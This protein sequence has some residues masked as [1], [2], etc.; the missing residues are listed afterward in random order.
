METAVR[1][2]SSGSRELPKLSFPKWREIRQGFI[3][4]FIGFVFL[5]MVALPGLLLLGPSKWTVV[6]TFGIRVDAAMAIGEVLAIFGGGA[7]YLF[8]VLGQLR[9]LI[10]SPQRHAGKELLFSAFLCS[11]T[12]PFLFLGAHFLDGDKNYAFITD[13]IHNLAYVDLLHGGGLLQLCGLGLT[14]LNILLFSGF[15]RGT[16]C[17]F[18]DERRARALTCYFWFMAFLVGGTFGMWLHSAHITHP[19]PWTALVTCWICALIFHAL[20]IYSA[21]HCVAEGMLRRPPSDE[22]WSVH[23]QSKPGEVFLQFGPH[24]QDR[25]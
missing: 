20:L 19:D 14:L 2:N 25:Q 12:T 21:I 24:F 6:S 5:F 10:S 11:I 22:N 18:N 16:A 17:Y 9:C 3:I 13:G 23:A 15:L 4:A 1:W 7:G 8:L